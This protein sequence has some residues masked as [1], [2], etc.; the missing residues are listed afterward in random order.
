ME[1]ASV[2]AVLLIL[3]ATLYAAA[4]KA[5]LSLTYAVT[6]LGVYVLEV[7]SSFLGI[8]TTSPIA[9]GFALAPAILRLPIPGR[10]SRPMGPARL[11]GLRDLATTPDLRHILEEAER[12]D[13]PETRDAWIEKFAATARCPSCGGPLRIR[14]GRLVSDCGWKHGL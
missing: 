8:V 10:I 13:L 5:L 11:L 9:F 3:L 2:A 6:I 12:A 14:L 1:P 7:A 4:R